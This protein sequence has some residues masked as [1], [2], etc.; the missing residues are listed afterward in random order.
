MSRFMDLWR[1][2]GSSRPPAPAPAPAPVPP[3]APAPPRAPAPDRAL[4]PQWQ[5]SNLLG[6]SHSSAKAAKKAAKQAAKAEAR[7]AKAEQAAALA[8][9]HTTSSNALK[10]M[11]NPASNPELL[12]VGAWPRGG[13]RGSIMGTGRHDGG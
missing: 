1:G 11:P 12:Y 9:A 5:R 6:Q 8:K 3:P 4:A 13:L 10:P 7:R 2:S